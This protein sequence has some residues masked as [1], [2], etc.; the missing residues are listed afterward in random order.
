MSAAKHGKTLTGHAVDALS[1]AIVFGVGYAAVS[2]APGHH[3]TAGLVGA[4]GFLLLAGTLVSQ[5]VEVVRLPHITGYLVAGL[6]AGPHV[7]HLIDHESVKRLAP[8][9]TLALALIALAGGAELRLDQVRKGLKSLAIATTLQ[10]VLVM[11][12]MTSVFVAV[13]PLLPFTA[14]LTAGGGLA[15]GLLWGV[16]ATTRSPSATL[17]ILSQT[18]AHGP[19][20]S[21]SLAFVM[22]S[23]VTVILLLAATMMVARPLL[24]PGASFSMGAFRV[25]GHEII[26]SV[27]LGTTLGLVLA[28]YMRLSGRK[29]LVVLIAVGFGATE[30]LHYLRFEP[31]LTFLVAGFVVQNLSKQGDRFLHAIEEMG[32]VVYVVFFAIAGADLD[33][34]LLRVLWPVALLL[35]GARAVVTY[36]THLL[37]SRIA[38]DPP[39]L[40]RYGWASLV[41]QAGLTQG[42]GALIERE[43]PSFGS[44]FKSLVFANVALN[45]V[46][47]PILFKLALDRA[48]ETQAPSPSLPDEGEALPPA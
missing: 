14:Q 37:S 28:A 9:N 40:R 41:A 21:F 16:V 31:L 30:V 46:I 47:G 5:L 45:A 26:G 22:L 29:L 12:A 38:K 48:G 7:L 2:L 1:L 43:F 35:G 17:G 33:I 8:V 3:D 24:E 23:D 27:S 18:R 4:L 44:P 32:G 6:V 42:M 13:R 36:A 15:V 34:P 10:S 20:A 25:L 19:V 11:V 39:E